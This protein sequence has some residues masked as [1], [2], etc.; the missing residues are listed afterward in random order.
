[1]FWF[2]LLMSVSSSPVSLDIFRNGVWDHIMNSYESN[3]FDM[4]QVLR[5]CQQSGWINPYERYSA[6]SDAFAC[7][8]VQYFSYL[9]SRQD[10]QPRESPVQLD[11]LKNSSTFEDFFTK[12]EETNLPVLFQAPNQLDTEQFISKCFPE[13]N[14]FKP[15]QCLDELT[16]FPVPK[17]LLNDFLP[18]LKLKYYSPRL[19]TATKSGGKVYFKCPYNMHTIVYSLLGQGDSIYLV[20]QA[21]LLTTSSLQ[22][23]HQLLNTRTDAKLNLEQVVEPIGELKPSEYLFVPYTWIAVIESQSSSQLVHFCSVDASNYNAFRQAIT[24]ASLVDQTAHETL[25]AMEN[26]SFDT[27]MERRPESDWIEYS[28]WPRKPKAKDAAT[29]TTT[30]RERFKLWQ[31]D[32]RWNQHVESIT[33]P[34]GLPP[35]AASIGRNNVTLV[36]QD[37]YKQHKEDITEHGYEIRWYQN[38]VHLTYFI[39][40]RTVAGQARYEREEIH[41]SEL[42]TDR[43][44]DQFDGFE[45]DV[46]VDQLQPNTSYCFTVALFTGESVGVESPCSQVIRTHPVTVPSIVRGIP[47]ATEPGLHYVTLSWLKPY[48]DGGEP[49]DHYIISRRELASDAMSTLEEEMKT[50]N[51]SYKFPYS[52]AV[53]ADSTTTQVKSLIPGRTYQFR[54]AGSNS[55]GIGL[56]SE[57]SA[58]VTLPH[59]IEETQV[60]HIS[61]KGHDDYQIVVEMLLDSTFVEHESH[62]PL[63][64]LSDKYEQLIVTDKALKEPIFAHVWSSHH[65]PNL[66][67]VSAEIVIALPQDAREPL[68]NADLVKDRIVFAERGTVP[69]RTKALH[70]QEAGALAIVIGDVN[71]QCNGVFDQHCSPGADQAHGEGFAAQDTKWLW[72]TI[73][74][75]C[76]LLHKNE[77]QA[78]MALIRSHS[79]QQLY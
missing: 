8:F 23:R 22:T 15:L 58:P 59:P 54:V 35:I 60:G 12:Y 30:R 79:K 68:K 64:Q 13:S 52:I 7:N 2:A 27:T 51:S 17:P 37:I 46:A 66:Y 49:I 71:G 77:S 21:S 19:Q 48:D 1:M 26:P 4:D 72:E 24:I 16:E 29:E 45:F 3:Q 55:K 78:L 44:G 32:N 63:V 10:L 70:A 39:E 38:P 11:V 53:S 62:G 65:S 75:P 34:M 6:L 33:L 67:N 9:I 56:W 14:I 25:L 40:G 74:I 76:V 41:R 20:D 5:Y 57:P 69:F 47:T 50:A 31:E 43:F 42:P 36:F 61:G 18:R 28:T 73:R